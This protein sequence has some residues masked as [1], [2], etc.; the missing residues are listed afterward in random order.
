[1]NFQPTDYLNNLNL[2]FDQEVSPIIN[3]DSNFSLNELD[4]FSQSEFFD[5]DVFSKDFIAP[6][7]QQQVAQPQTKLNRP[8]PS[9]RIIQQQQLQQQL[10]QQQIQQQEQRQ[11]QQQIEEEEADIS[12]QFLNLPEQQD[13]ISS[14]PIIKLESENKLAESITSSS[15]PSSIIEHELDNRV[16]KPDDKRKRN[17]AAS[18]RFRIKKK[19]KE[20]QMEEHA[21]LLQDRVVNLEKKLKTLEME[22]KCLKNL[23]LQ[24]NEKNSNDLLESIKKRSSNFS[25]TT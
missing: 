13:S 8:Q 16:A 25:Y 21:K 17:T 7:K 19:L 4:L 3:N 9:Q 23:I 18:A 20:Q 1:M 6:S 24:K 11:S 22:N 2:D 10:Q 12:L 5:L 14:S 15:S